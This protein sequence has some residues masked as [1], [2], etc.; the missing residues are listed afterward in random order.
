MVMRHTYTL[1]ILLLLL[2]LSPALS[3][4]AQ[5]KA[6]PDRTW[7]G[8]DESFNLELR[9]DGSLDGDPDLSVLEQDFE[10]L[11]RSQSSQM[12]IINTDITRTT[13][14]SLSLLAR[15]AGRKTI[16][17]ICVENDCSKPVI[18]DVRPRR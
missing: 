18:I 10:L 7:V 5:L 15:S 1:L 14:W 11:G 4:S 8:L 2:V 6:V 13:T 17:A 9:A 16:P 3:L 12:Q